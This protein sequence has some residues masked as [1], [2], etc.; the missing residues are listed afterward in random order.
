MRAGAENLL[1]H[2]CENGVSADRREQPVTV[3]EVA[4]EVNPGEDDDGG[5]RRQFQISQ[6]NVLAFPRGDG[7]ESRVQTL[8]I[9]FAWLQHNAPPDRPP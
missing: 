9:L 4:R 1:V 3:E 7:L 5:D 8:A 2:H 6:E